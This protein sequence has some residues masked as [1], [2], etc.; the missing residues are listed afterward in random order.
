K[1]FFVD[2]STIER[3]IEVLTPLVRV[4]F[5][6]VDREVFGCMSERKNT[7]FIEAVFLDGVV[8]IHDRERR[9]RRSEVRAVVCQRLIGAVVTRQVTSCAIA[10]RDGELDVLRRG[11]LRRLLLLLVLRSFTFGL[12]RLENL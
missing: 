12:L 11:L 4:E 6:R 9:S 3:A 10:I 2:F 5:V 8:C 7:V 1:G